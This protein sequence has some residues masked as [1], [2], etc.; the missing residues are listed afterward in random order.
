MWPCDC[1]LPGFVFLCGIVTARCQDLWIFCDN[2]TVLP[3]FVVCHCS[4]PGFVFLVWQCDCSLQG[5]VFLVRHT[6]AARVCFSCVALLLCQNSFFL[7]WHWIARCQ[8]FFFVIVTARCQDLFFFFFC[9]I[10]I[11]HYQDLISFC[12]ILTARFMSFLV[13]PCDCSLPGFF[14]PLCLVTTRCQCFS[15]VLL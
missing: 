8:I 11:V 7:V 2:V 4:L 6:V 9:G 3:G 14:F 10:V 1:S 15:C 5:F 13:W 12:G